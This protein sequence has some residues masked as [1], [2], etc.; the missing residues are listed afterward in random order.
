MEKQGSAYTVPDLAIDF[1]SGC[2]CADTELWRPTLSALV[3]KKIPSVFTVSMPLRTHVWASL[4][5]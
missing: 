3:A 5:T 1:N 4:V 2:G